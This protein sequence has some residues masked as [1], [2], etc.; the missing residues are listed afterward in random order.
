M[1]LLTFPE[2]EPRPKDTHDG[3]PLSAKITYDSLYCSVIVSEWK[4]EFTNPP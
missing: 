3:S 1:E 4:L 2:S